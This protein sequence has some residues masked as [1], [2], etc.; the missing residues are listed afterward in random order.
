MGKR[1]CNSTIINTAESA[2]VKKK[3]KNDGYIVY[4]FSFCQSR[5]PTLLSQRARSMAAS[6]NCG[7]A[8]LLAEERDPRRHI[9]AERSSE[10]LSLQRSQLSVWL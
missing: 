5:E 4:C 6:C 9:M 3:K 8:G 1:N 7:W 2:T 10:K